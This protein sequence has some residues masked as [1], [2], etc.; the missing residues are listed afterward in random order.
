MDALIYTIM[1]GAN[2]T[3]KA[4]Q[5]RA[6]NLANADT[7]GFR[8]DIE[9]ASSQV[10]PGYGYDARQVARIIRLTIEGVWLDMMTMATPYSREAGLA[11]AR[12]CAALCFPAHFT[13]DGLKADRTRA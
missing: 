6:N 3:L 13:P 7:P 10:V 9:V 5:V 1:S 2:R 12:T 4:Q 8:A 11:T